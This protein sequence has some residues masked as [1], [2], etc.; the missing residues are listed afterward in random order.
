MIINQ[1]ED[2]RIMDSGESN[3]EDKSILPN[4]HYQKRLSMF[5]KGV[6]SGSSNS[7][8]Y[9]IVAKNGQSRYK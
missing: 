3:L 6:A 4:I 7:P 5:A 9:V 2:L 8:R 1:S